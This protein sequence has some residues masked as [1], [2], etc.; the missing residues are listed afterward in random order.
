MAEAY[1]VFEYYLTGRDKALSFNNDNLWDKLLSGKEKKISD[2]PS[3]DGF[4]LGDYFLSARTF[5]GK[6]NFLFL[7]RGLEQELSY[8]VDFK[9]IEKI[10]LSLEKHGPFYHP[11]KVTVLLNNI[12]PAFFVLN[13]AVSDIGLAT[14]ENEYQNLKSLN[15]DNLKLNTFLPIVFGQ[16]FVE[17]KK[18]RAGF[19]LA[20]WFE[21]YEEFHVVS[22]ANINKDI[23][24]KIGLLKEDGTFSL[25]S[26]LMAFKIYEKAAEILTFYYDIKSMKQIF[27]WH[28]A[29]G[30]FIVKTGE[31]DLDVKLITIRGYDT[32]MEFDALLDNK[33]KHDNFLLG[34]LFFF[35]NLTLRMR[36]DR[37]RGTKGYI[38]L[39]E[40]VVQASVNGFI[41][42]LKENLKK[43]QKLYRLKLDFDNLFIEFIKEFE[44]KDLLN[45]FIMITGS[46]S[47]ST[48]EASIIEQ[49]LEQHAKTV[50]ESI[51]RL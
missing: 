18:R 42:G 46:Y 16:S 15:P 45:V 49:N 36:I 7:K 28:H 26:D 43:N 20:Q 51:Q 12:K 48:P 21:N 22:S 2:D 17:S 47:K 44:L 27:P 50:F 25:L 29:A 9:E 41:N 3:F 1:P 39:D 38:F 5:L 37:D 10:I 6:N 40:F 11:I 32:L 31:R 34:L 24:N 19:F 35:V 8:D 23:V 30:D 4:T 13:G 33:E 14:I